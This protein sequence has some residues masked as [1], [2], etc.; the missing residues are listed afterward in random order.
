MLSDLSPQIPPRSAHGRRGRE[1][2]GRVQ[3]P[4][5]IGQMKAELATDWGPM[6]CVC[7]PRSQVWEAERWKLTHPCTDV[8]PAT[9]SCVPLNSASKPRRVPNHG[10]L[11]SAL[12]R[13]AFLLPGS[14][15][16]GDREG[17]S[18]RPVFLEASPLATLQVESSQ[19]LAEACVTSPFPRH[20]GGR[21]GC[22]LLVLRP[23]HTSPSGSC[24]PDSA[25]PVLAG[26][27]L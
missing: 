25:P 20:G 13:L 2:S 8:V 26:S 4:P 1:S 3:G 18:P 23:C 19:P 16:G 21:G 14:R 24:P 9:L 11:H 27:S 5:A 10:A 17:S 6:R 12:P 7:C 22:C 15:W